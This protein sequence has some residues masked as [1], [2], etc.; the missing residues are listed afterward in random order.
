MTVEIPGDT[1][2]KKLRKFIK[3]LLAQEYGSLPQN[4]E[5]MV[6]R[7][8]GNVMYAISIDVAICAEKSKK[9]VET[10]DFD[11]NVNKVFF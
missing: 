9:V 4:I 1:S 8:T 11:Q 6:D 3:K 5:V 7:A 2:L 10:D